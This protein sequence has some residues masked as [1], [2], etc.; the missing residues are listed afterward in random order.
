IP[1][2]FG[3]FTPPLAA[4]TFYGRFL[5]K[6]MAAAT[7]SAF[8]GAKPKVILLFG[9]R[10]TGKS[11]LL[12]HCLPPS[13]DTLILNLQDPRLRRR[14]EA[15][16]EALV[17]ELEA[18][19]RV[20]TV[21]VDEIQKV[22]ALLD[23]VQYLYDADPRRFRF[24]LTGSS[25]RRLKR[26]S[27]N[28]LPG[29]VHSLLLSP[30]IQAESRACVLA[31]LPAPRAPRF[32]A[33]PLEDYL[34]YG[35][36]PGLYQESRSDWADTLAAYVEL[37]VE[38]EIRQENL[39]QDMGAFARFL[40]L[41][42]VESGQLVNFTKLANAVGVTPNTL[43]NFY[44]VLEDTHVGIRIQPFGRSR[45]R[46]LQAPRFIIFDIG[47]RHALAELPPTDVLLKLDPGHVF[48]QWVFA[49]LY[50]RC[51]Y[52]GPGHKLSTWTTATGAEVDAIVETPTE[53]I[54]VEI[55]WTDTPSHRDARHVETFL[56]LHAAVAKRGYV[57]CRCPRQQALSR[58]VTALPWNEF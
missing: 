12:G 6:R 49:E 42:A 57:V 55:K 19:P 51:R 5:G 26:R 39:A 22:P 37:Y 21:V 58:Q 38:N 32:P 14:Y 1:P 44:Q 31:P 48:E 33:R 3:T 45:K 4:D 46:I 35:S 2:L 13:A 47:V 27:A 25:A 30:A 7:G 15:D 16:P 23:A 17:C 40:R 56:A 9:A 29:R 41:A 50:Y 11:T 36:L 52:A 10:Q 8:S 43:R 28:L 34:L 20:R 24:F 18:S 53:V 54:P